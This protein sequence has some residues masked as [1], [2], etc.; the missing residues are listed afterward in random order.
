MMNC[1]NMKFLWETCEGSV[2]G[3]LSLGLDFVVCFMLSFVV[4]RRASLRGWFD[5]VV[6]LSLSFVRDGE[7]SGLW[8]RCS[9][10]R[11]V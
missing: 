5:G 6:V 2:G 10:R 7:R 4:A 1:V 3:L 9:V 8:G 11:L